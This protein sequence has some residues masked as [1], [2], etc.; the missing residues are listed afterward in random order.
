MVGAP[1]PYYTMFLNDDALESY[2][3]RTEFEPCP[4][5][6]FMIFSVPLGNVRI[7]PRIGNDQFLPCVFEFIVLPFDAVFCTQWGVESKLGPVGTAVIFTV[8]LCLPRVIVR[9]ENCS[10]E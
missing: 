6:V 3:G 1:L 4:T 7:V 2:S 5:E 10:V 9:M 8:L